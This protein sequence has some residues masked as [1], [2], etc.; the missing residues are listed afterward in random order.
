MHVAHA[1]TRKICVG[2]LLTALAQAFGFEPVE[3]VHIPLEGSNL[4][5][6]HTLINMRMCQHIG[7]GQFRLLDYRGHII[8]PQDDEGHAEELYQE[9]GDEPEPDQPHE[10]MPE[11]A[12]DMSEFLGHHQETHP[13]WLIERFER[14]E[15]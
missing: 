4:V 2:G 15:A 9:Q 13:D 8:E 6:M 11:P 10:A 5:D 14:L 1:P 7:G 12:V 3:R